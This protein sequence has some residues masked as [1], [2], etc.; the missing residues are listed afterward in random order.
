LA[1]WAGIDLGTSGVK[2]ALFGADDKRLAVAAQATEVSRPYPGWS[3]QHP[4]IWWDAVVAC[5]DELA[6]GHTKSLAALRGIGLSGQMLGPVFLDRDLEP[7]RPAMLWNDQRALAQCGELLARVPDIGMRANGAPDPG[8]V[9]PKLLWLALHEPALLDAAR[10]LLLPKDYVRL[11][12]TGEIA[13]EPTD[14][15][16][17]M[18]MDCASGQWDDELCAAAGWSTDRL[19]KIGTTWQSAGILR[20]DHAVR[21]GIPRGVAVA[22]GAGDNMACTI[23]VGAARPGDGAISIGTSAVVN[24]VDRVFHPIPDKAVLTSAHA[25]P[26]TFLSMGVVMSATASLDWLARLTGAAPADLAGEAERFA[27]SDAL[28]TAPVMRPSLSGLRTPHNR[29]DASG[30]IDGLRQATDRPALAYALLE[31]VAFQIAECAAAQRS[32]GVPF[33]DIRLVGGGAR[34]AL[35]PRLIATLLECELAVPEGA[36]LSANIGAARLARVASGDAAT[37]CLNRSLPTASAFAPDRDL[38]QCLF[39]R[40]AVYRTLPISSTQT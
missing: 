18:L 27:A 4:D 10:L 31:G 40:F 28:A 19:P 30:V 22:A 13:T 38:R 36:A 11:R 1:V 14:A 32:A 37:D 6:A 23:G 7:L 3:E 8:I 35:W 39:D 26:A 21:W 29:P 9:A 2:V 25:A 12:L 33:S 17:T 15:G 5:F 24:V 16:G 34:S 20:D